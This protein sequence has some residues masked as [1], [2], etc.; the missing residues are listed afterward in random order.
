MAKS[1]SN[2]Q[3]H[4]LNFFEGDMEKLAALHPDLE[5]SVVVRTLVRT[6]IESIENAVTRPA[7]PKIRIEND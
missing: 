6:H 1:K 4:T 7:L 5:P 3:K 2:F